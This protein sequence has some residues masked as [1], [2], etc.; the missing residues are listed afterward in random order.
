MTVEDTALTFAASSLAANDAAGPANESAQSLTVTEVQAT[1]DTHG[2]VAL[3]AGDVT[4]TPAADYYGPASFSYTVCD[5]GT[6]NGAP[7]AQCATG[8]VNVTVTEVNDAPTANADSGTV[9]EDSASGVLVDVVAN[10][11][12]GTGERVGSDVDG[13][14]GL[15]A[16]AR[17]GDDRVEPGPLRPDG[18]E[19]QRAG[20]LHLHRPRQRDDERRPELRGRTQ[21]RSQ[22]PSRR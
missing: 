18:G 22:S 20:Q 21:R 16:C 10:D 5:D 12:R 4:Y 13:R 1:A 15:G 6:T 3:V 19:L 8:T 17:D 7:D 11:S 9:A 14:L 2:T